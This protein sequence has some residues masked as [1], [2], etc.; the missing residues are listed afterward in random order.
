MENQI[1][2]QYAAGRRRDW[3]GGDYFNS[4]GADRSCHHFQIPAYQSGADNFRKDYQRKR[5]NLERSDARKLKGEITVFLSLIFILLV[6][7]A[8]AVMESA[9]IQMAKNYRRADMNRAIE[10]VFA[11]YQK[12]L[13]EEYEIFALD[14][15]YETGRYSEQNLID[16][17]EY[18]GAGSMEHRISRIQFLTDHGCQSFL[19]QTAY[20]MEQKYGIDKVKDWTGMTSVW[21]Q[22]EDQ[23]GKLQ[24]EEKEKEQELEDL[25][26]ANEG[27]LPEEE[28][29]IAH[30]GELQQSPILKLVL[31]KDAAVS[32]KQLAEADL[33]EHR[34][35]NTGWGDFSD[36]AE[37][38]GT[39]TTLL[40]GEYL[41]EHFSMFTDEE[42]TGALDYEL[43]YILEGKASDREN[44]EAVVKK[45]MLLRFVP[46]YAYIQTDAAMKAEAEAMALTL[47]SLL[48]V[49]A[50]TAAAAQV[51]LL[52]WA[53]GETV[54]DLRSLLSGNRVPL[55]KSKESWQLSLSSLLTLG[56][57]EDQSEGMDTEGGLLYREYLRMLLFLEKQ[58]SCAVRALGIIEQ[59]LRQRHGQA[60]FRAD[61]CVSRMEIVSA[62]TLRRGIRYDFPT[63]F[64][65]Q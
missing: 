7:F 23:A 27:E 3:C 51:I 43:E 11:E 32:E 52:A 33:L 48:A 16:R 21:G 8:G 15:G 6:S 18:Y 41:L 47:C 9:S 4:C 1:F 2:N 10:S 63:Y 34:E 55:I 12:E 26:N 29:P 56:T 42:K 25:L 22:Q 44:L 54:M 50:I 60:G 62:V 28:N 36:V 37:A 30:V 53:Y 13:L 19:E 31:P 14:A 61:I 40:F 57:E 64:G 20:Y 39:I 17:L 38:G 5:G 49:P 24:T 35:K 45:L 65:Y 59:N 46:N 58:E